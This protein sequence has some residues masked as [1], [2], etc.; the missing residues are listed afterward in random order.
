MYSHRNGETELPT[1]IGYFWFSGDVRGYPVAEQVTV[2]QHIGRGH[3]MVIGAEPSSFIGDFEG[4]WYGPIVAPWESQ[5]T[6]PQPERIAALEYAVEQL[7]GGKKDDE[8]S[9]LYGWL[10]D[11]LAEIQQPTAPQMEV[12]EEVYEA[13]DDAVTSWSVE[14]MV[15]WH[16]GHADAKTVHERTAKVDMVRE[17]LQL[18]RPRPQDESEVIK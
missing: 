18:M 10:C 13:I 3:L 7:R 4:Q 9:D 11:M 5:P 2:M 15:D 16:N 12:S 1:I 8:E 6:A 14:A 17:W